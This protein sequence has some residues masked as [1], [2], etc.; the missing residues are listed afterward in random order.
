MSQSNLYFLCMVTVLQ[1]N[2]NLEW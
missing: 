2:T 1:I